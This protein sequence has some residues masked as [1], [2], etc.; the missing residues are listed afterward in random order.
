ME[1]RQMKTTGFQ[2]TDREILQKAFNEEFQRDFEEA[3]ARRKELRRRQAQQ[4]G[5]MK[6]RLHMESL[7]QEEFN[8][9]ASN[10]QVGLTIDYIKENMLHG[11]LRV[12]VN[13]TSARALAKAM[14]SNST[15]VS[16]DL[17]ANDLNDHSGLYLARIL[18]RNQSLERLDLDNN[19]LG[20]QT[21]A[22]FG[23]SLMKN[24]TLKHLNLDSNP[25]GSGDQAGL[26]KMIE[27]L[28]YNKTLVSLNLWRTSI[29]PSMG[30]ILADAIEYNDTLLFLDIGKNDINMCDT[31]KIVTKIEQNLK[32]F[33]MNER[34]RRIEL[35]QETERNQ[36]IQKQEETKV[37]KQ[38]IS[39]WLEER[40]NQ[41]AESRRQ[42]EEERIAS[43]FPV[44]LTVDS[45]EHCL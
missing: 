24:S 43:K 41:R 20:S 6:R 35:Q 40:R 9:L 19:N 25:L 1:K 39:S 36:T 37:K 12:E 4:A 34:I 13:S 18:N 21:C 7:L 26:K 45:A 3:K 15:I 14:W 10:H 16:L 38:Q 23:E 33:E 42:A 5:L 17:S 44:K 22:A 8:E 27:A 2:D 11:S 32:A 31:K 28:K 30:S 29:N